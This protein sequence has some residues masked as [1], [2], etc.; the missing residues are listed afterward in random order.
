[1]IELYP[2][3]TVLGRIL[4]GL[5]FVAMGVRCAFMLPELAEAVAARS[6]PRPRL[7]LIGASA[8]QLVA[9]ACLMLGYAVPVAAFALIAFTLAAS[10]V[11]LDFW[12]TRLAE[13]ELFRN[14]WLSNLAII[15]GLLI[16]AS[17]AF[18]VS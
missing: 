14:L 17:Q 13:E 10:A 12:K 15:G 7:I 4:M 16:A 2:I 1:M 3:L 9:G 6:L 5:L 18:G 11:M 8:F